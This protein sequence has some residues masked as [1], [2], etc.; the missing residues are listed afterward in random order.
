MF[1]MFMNGIAW[2][3]VLGLALILL[4]FALA[5]IAAVIGR[6]LVSIFRRF[7]STQR[8]NSANRAAG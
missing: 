5:G 3:I 2:L 8:R 7:A 6:V 4:M 1:M